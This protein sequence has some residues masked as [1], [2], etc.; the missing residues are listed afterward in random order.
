MS[1][2]HHN[3]VVGLQ[4]V[5]NGGQVTIHIAEVYATRQGVESE[6]DPEQPDS[7]QQDMPCQFERELRELRGIVA[8]Y[9]AAQDAVLADVNEASKAFANG[10]LVDAGEMSRSRQRL[11]GALRRLKACARRAAAGLN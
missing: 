6:Q 8:E 1:S 7:G 10:G 5:A 3:P 11:A 2:S 4:V 9:T